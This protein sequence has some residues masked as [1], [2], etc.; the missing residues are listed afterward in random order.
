MALVARRD[1]SD[2]RTKDQA[3]RRLCGELEERNKVIGTLENALAKKDAELKE[4][5]KD[6]KELDS[7]NE[8]SSLVIRRFEKERAIAPEDALD[9][10]TR[11][12]NA[13]K[14][15]ERRHI[16]LRKEV[17]NLPL[18]TAAKDKEL[19][20][21]QSELNYV[22]E[23]TG[24]CA[25]RKPMD[26]AHFEQSMAA[27]QEMEQL[28]RRLEDERKTMNLILRKK[29]QLIE[30]LRTELLRKKE[31]ED[32]LLAANNST[33][34]MDRD[35]REVQAEILERR[36]EHSKHDMAIVA[37]E[38][39]RDM[40]CLNS[41][42][43]DVRFLQGEVDRNAQVTKEQARLIKAQQFR[44]EQLE[45]RVACVM[46]AVESLGLEREAQ[47]T[48]RNVI[49]ASTSANIADITVET[50]LP[51]NEAIDAELFEALHRD[52]TEMRNSSSMKDIL[53]LEKGA[54]FEALARKMEIMIQAKRIESQVF[55]QERAEQDQQLYELRRQLE[56]QQ[57][58]WMAQLKEP[59]RKRL[60]MQRQLTKVL[61]DPVVRK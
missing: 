8:A 29:E 48:L 35:V 37:V 25:G 27:I 2:L 4:V 18:I 33:R 3:S 14:I 15:E 13:L 43:E 1:G 31:L 44:T 28:I 61:T 46:E 6:I 7:L 53:T 58:T 56:D 23:V 36:K 39:S 34:V 42:E 19:E 20:G 60:N 54:T 59:T 52:L 41:L 24:W 38:S 45:A 32:Q 16:V 22:T 17:H 47:A 9:A 40:V 5:E 49:S 10:I 11:K 55:E 50:V 26:A 51:A 57:H 30:T 21:V 12:E